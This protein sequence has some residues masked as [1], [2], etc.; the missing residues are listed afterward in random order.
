M[1]L[2]FFTTLICFVGGQDT[3]TSAVRGATSIQLTALSGISTV[4][5]DISPSCTLS[6]KSVW[7][8]REILLLQNYMQ[9]VFGVSI[10]CKSN[11]YCICTESQH[12]GVL[13]CHQGSGPFTWLGHRYGLQS[14]TLITDLVL[15]VSHEDLHSAELLSSPDC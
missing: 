9:E 8:F 2:H 14:W 13:Q 5:V 15:E 10:I 6:Q 3:A 4:T 11:F 12:M 1:P 7:K